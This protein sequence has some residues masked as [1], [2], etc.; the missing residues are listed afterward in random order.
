MSNTT[1]VLKTDERRIYLQAEETLLEAMERSEIDCEYQCRQ[2]YCG[3][4]RMRLLNG[5][6]CYR[7]NVLAY[8]RDGEILICSAKAQSDMQIT[9][10]IPKT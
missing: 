1:F 10:L 9:K 2:G 3:H 6:F 5:N 4:C 8:V 7:S